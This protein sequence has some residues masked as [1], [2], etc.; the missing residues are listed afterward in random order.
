MA[1]Y[2]QTVRDARQL[3]RD[4]AHGLP[5]DPAGLRAIHLAMEDQASEIM[6]LRDRLCKRASEW[7]VSELAR[8]LSLEN[9]NLRRPK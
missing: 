3:A 2:S 4:Y 8:E 7:Q 9:E 6:A 1:S 5:V